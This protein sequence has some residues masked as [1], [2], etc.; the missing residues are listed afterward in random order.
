MMSLAESILA[1]GRA[2]RGR[3]LRSRIFD[4]LPY[5][6]DIRQVG[7]KG[8][9]KEEVREFNGNVRS[10]ASAVLN[11]LKSEIRYNGIDGNQ[12]IGSLKY[13]VWNKSGEIV[14]IGFQFLRAGVFVHY[15]AGRGQGGF[16]GSRW[17]TREGD[18]K[19][20]D[21]ESLTKMGSG[22]R[23]PKPWFDPVIRRNIPELEKIVK[24]YASDAT[25]DALRIYIDR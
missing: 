11:E 16:K 14:R 8:R 5:Y 6:L 24:A 2:R 10:W 7:S 4:E 25:V 19:S 22:N 13:R 15:G 21:W 17:R 12:L 1:D 9:S 20:T 3:S 23:R 18:I